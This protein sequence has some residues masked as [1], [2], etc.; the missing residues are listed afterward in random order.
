MIDQPYDFS[1]RRE[2]P[3]GDSI[4]KIRSKGLCRLK[5]KE[6]VYD[7]RYLQIIALYRE[8]VYI[9]SKADLWFRKEIQGDKDKEINKNLN[10]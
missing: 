10:I 2:R 6:P 8:G 5:M 9:K 4:L 3:K 1:N 7:Q